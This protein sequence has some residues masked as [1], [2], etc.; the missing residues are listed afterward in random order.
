MKEAEQ[1]FLLEAQVLGK[2]VTY[3]L[4]VEPSG[5]DGDF[6]I[7]VSGFGEQVRH[8]HVFTDK[9]EAQKFLELLCRCTVTPTTVTDVLQDYLDERDFVCSLD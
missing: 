3:E 1:E 7:C 8:S 6:G 5:E 2:T 4:L 9:K